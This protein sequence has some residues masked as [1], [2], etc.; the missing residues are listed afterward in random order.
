MAKL[1][2]I[3]KRMN[4]LLSDK[5]EIDRILAQGAWRRRGAIAGPV[6]E[7][8]HGYYGLLVLGFELRAHRPE[9][10]DIDRLLAP[11]AFFRG[12]VFQHIMKVKA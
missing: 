4:E 7:G 1:A 10:D 3:T 11:A 12:N 8:R 9:T 2:P 6:L 5:A